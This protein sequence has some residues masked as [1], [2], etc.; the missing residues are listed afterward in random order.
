MKT[1]NEITPQILLA[2]GFEIKEY[3]D[4]GLTFYSKEIKDSHSL[5]KLIAHHYDIE[6]SEDIETDSTSFIM[7]VQTNG[8][9]PQWIFTGQHEMFDIFEDI[10]QFLEYVEIIERLIG[11]KSE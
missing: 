2:K 11:F 6:D 8:E 10:N 1:S 7:E 3:D 4:Q 9:T 5:R